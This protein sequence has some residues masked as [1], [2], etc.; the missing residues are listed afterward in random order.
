MKGSLIHLLAASSAVAVLWAPCALAQIEPPLEGPFPPPP[1]RVRPSPPTVIVTPGPQRDVVTWQE[2]VPNANLVAGGI[3]TLG[4]SYGTSVVVG[5]ISD[6]PA[7]QFLFVPVAGP[8]LN[9]ASRDC[10]STPCGLGEAG[11]QVLLVTN[12]IVQAAGVLEIVAGFLLPET[13]TV[14]RVGQVHVTPTGGPGSIGLSAHG[15]F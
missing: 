7:D 4:L 10:R 14:T 11:N 15:A 5:A 2:R 8:W 6:R 13:R 1:V 9:L 12:G 3:F